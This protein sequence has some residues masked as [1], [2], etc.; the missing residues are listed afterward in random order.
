MLD[1][2]GNPIHNLVTVIAC[3]GG[4]KSLS[5]WITSN[6]RPV[7]IAQDISVKA[8]SDLA[9]SPDGTSLFATA[10]DGA[11]IAVRFE[12]AELG[13]PMPV[14]ENEKSL[15]K[16]GTNRRGAGM[17]ESTDSLL[18]EEKSKAGELRGVKGRMGA[19]MG[20]GNAD[21]DHTVNGDSDATATA[22]TA[23]KTTQNE[24][25]AQSGVTNGTDS[26][27]GKQDPYAVKLDRLKQRP[28][29]TKEGKKRIA[30]LLI[31]GS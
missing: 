16:F 18:L 29:Y 23:Q 22:A 9:W 19:L 20:D 21:A 11:I 10:L 12:N 4:D 24:K 30:P 2:H 28:T 14:E 5:I 26:N 15:S 6:P 3:A 8:I 31:S 1:N 27:Q 25:A 13:H 17:V 7:V